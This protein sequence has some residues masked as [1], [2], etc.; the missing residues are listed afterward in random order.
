MT[1]KKRIFENKGS[2]RVTLPIVFLR[3]LNI[4]VNDMVDVEVD[5]DKIIITKIK[6]RQQEVS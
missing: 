6:D 1:I 3:Q 4:G 2:H 5:G